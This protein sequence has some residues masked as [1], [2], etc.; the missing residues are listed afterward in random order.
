[1]SLGEIQEEGSA[2]LG[3]YL[4]VGDEREGGLGEDSLGSGLGDEVNAGPLLLEGAQKGRPDW[5]KVMSDF[6]AWWA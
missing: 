4:E 1:M 5:G 3:D 6:E 2:K